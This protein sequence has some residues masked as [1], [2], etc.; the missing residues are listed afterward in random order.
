MLKVG[1][2]PGVSYEWVDNS[3]TRNK[4]HGICALAIP[5]WAEVDDIQEIIDN[6]H[7]YHSNQI[8]L[9]G[10]YNAD[11]GD[12]PGEVIMYDDAKILAEWR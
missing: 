12:D 6:L 1:S 10:S 2:S 7:K 3:P 5:Y 8:V 4:L 11:Y 9:I